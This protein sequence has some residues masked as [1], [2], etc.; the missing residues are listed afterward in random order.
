MSQI[1]NIYRLLTPNLICLT[2]IQIG[3]AILDKDEMQLKITLP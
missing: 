3:M 1:Q 2:K